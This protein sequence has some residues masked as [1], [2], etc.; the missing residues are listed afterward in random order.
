MPRAVIGDALGPLEN[1]AVR[2]YDPGPPGRGEVQLAV[3]AVG[4]S[5]VDVLNAR[6]L[7]Q[8]KAPVPFIPGSECAGVV[9]AVGEGVS[10]LVPGDRV[11][12]TNWGGIL[13]ER[14][15]LRARQC[16]PMPDA[17]DFATAS[18]FLVSAQT[19]WHALVDRAG[20]RRGETLL[21]LGAGGATGLAAVQIGRHLGARV[22][23]SASSAQKRRLALDA[24]ADAAIVARGP[25]WRDAVTAAC[26]GGKPDVVF[27]PV[28]G[29]A[30]EQAFRTLGYGGR[31]LVVGFP[32]GIAQ[33]PSNLPLL[34][35]ASMVGVNL[36]Q[37][38]IA[39]P[40]AAQANA[41]K[42]VALGGQGLFHPAIA[43]TYPLEEFAAAMR[44]VERGESA[45]RIVISMD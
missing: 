28:G 14:T 34:K 45:G 13:A 11:F 27:D 20:L 26:E 35:A 41:V 6:G 44:E 31:H 21:V 15:N 2:E 42:L 10:G 24:G 40:E 8:A 19:S 33:L 12:A 17:M 43:R 4:I 18:V 23:A 37:F 1:Y 3:K 16:R 30:T 22:I 7:Y 9:E 5:F 39:H 38:G 29:S 36:Q 32:A 25:D